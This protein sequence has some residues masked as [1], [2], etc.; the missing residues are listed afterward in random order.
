MK[1]PNPQPRSP[2]WPRTFWQ[3]LYVAWFVIC[4][5]M[6]WL[7][8]WAVNRPV[9]IFGLPLVFVWCTGWGVLGLAGCLGC[10]LAIERERE[11]RRGE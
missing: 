9:P 5:L 1:S 3:K 7:G 2:L 4:F 11:R 8:T 10:G 6:V